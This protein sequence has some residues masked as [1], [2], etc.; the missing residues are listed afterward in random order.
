MKTLIFIL[1][2]FILPVNA[3]I[4]TP[5]WIKN[6]AKE[7][8]KYRWFVYNS[9]DHTYTLIS[10]VS[11]D[12]T[13]LK[14]SNSILNEDKPLFYGEFKD[15][16]TKAKLTGWM[17]YH[18][19]NYHSFH[20]ATFA[21]SILKEYSCEEHVT[22]DYYETFDPCLIKKNK[23]TILGTFLRIYDN[24]VSF[25]LLIR[26]DSKKDLDGFEGYVKM[27]NGNGRPVTWGGGSNIFN[28]SND[29]YCIKAGKVSL[30]GSWDLILYSS[31]KSIEPK[32]TRL[33]FSK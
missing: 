12:S 21:D 2:L 19:N 10:C 18:Q 25:Q 20:L 5:N 33:F 1:L 16:Y 31:T 17:E 22:S 13:S 24:R 3:Q 29:T 27:Y 14:K 8:I 30:I 6:E 32:L 4:Y 23:I 9:E 7:L 15:Y 11:I 28:F 26:N